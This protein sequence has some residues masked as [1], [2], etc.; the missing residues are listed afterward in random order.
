MFLEC[1][2]PN[3][4]AWLAEIA[5]HLTPDLYAAEIKKVTRPVRFITVHMHP[6]HRTEVAPELMAMKLPNVEIG[7]AGRT[8]VI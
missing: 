7:E 8:Y 5:H 4:L 1:T 6:R 3:S 2:F